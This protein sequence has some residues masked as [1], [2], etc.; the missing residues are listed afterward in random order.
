FYLG[1]ICVGIVFLLT[2]GGF[3]VWWLID[4]C[5]I[6]SMVDATNIRNGLYNTPGGMTTVVNSMAQPGYQPQ[7]PVYQPMQQ[8]QYAP[9]PAMVQPQQYPP[10]QQYAPEP[11]S[12]SQY[13]P[14]QPQY[15]PQPV[16]QPGY[17]MDHSPEPMDQTNTYPM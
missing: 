7:Q 17:P 12:Q 6:P 13:P 10:Q 16:P 11:I 14:Q 1:Q 9:Q 3:G 4:A 15:A 5:L 8:P 2:F